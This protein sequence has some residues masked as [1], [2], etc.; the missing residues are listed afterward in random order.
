M[1]W[2]EAIEEAKQELGYLEGEYISNWSEVVEEA[3]DILQYHNEEEY[4][5]LCQEAKEDYAERLKS[6]YWKKLRKKRLNMDKGKCKDCGAKATQ[7]HHKRYVNLGT[8][9]EIYELVSLC[10]N[11]HEKRHKIK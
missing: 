8:P 11:C 10:K 7:V 4:K 6:D 2:Q 9:W 5:N 3:K 1:K